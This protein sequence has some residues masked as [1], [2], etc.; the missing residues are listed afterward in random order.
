[1]IA[2]KKDNME[3]TTTFPQPNQN[4]GHLVQIFTY[5]AGGYTQS[6]TFR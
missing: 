5:Q 4:T 3:Q 2:A 1:M 6:R